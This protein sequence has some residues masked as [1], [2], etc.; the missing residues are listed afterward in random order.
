MAAMAAATAGSAVDEW[1]TDHGGLAGRS[2]PR[3]PRSTP[4]FANIFCAGGNGTGA[5][6]TSDDF[7]NED[8]VQGL[9]VPQTQDEC[10]TITLPLLAAYIGDGAI[11]QLNC[12]SVG[13]Q[14]MHHPNLQ[15]LT[16]NLQPPTSNLPSPM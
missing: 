4:S 1:G 16:S 14:A 11:D 2:T 10:Y 12:A 3:N 15:P 9:W 7:Y 5:D 13:F 8:G 6:V